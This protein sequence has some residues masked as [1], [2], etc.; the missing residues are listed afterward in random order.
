M[1]ESG[2]ETHSAFLKIECR[3]LVLFRIVELLCE[4]GITSTRV[5]NSH[6]PR[7]D[8]LVQRE[9]LLRRGF[10]DII[11]TVQNLVRPFTCASDIFHEH[12]L[13]TTGK[14]LRNVPG[15]A[16]PQPLDFLPEDSD[17]LKELSVWTFQIGTS[18]PPCNSIQK[19]L[20]YCQ[21]GTAPRKIF[22][23]QANPKISNPKI[24]RG[25]GRS[26]DLAELKE[27]FEAVSVVR[28]VSPT[29]VINDRGGGRSAEDLAL[30]F[31]ARPTKKGL[32]RMWPLN[33]F[34]GVETLHKCVANF[35]DLFG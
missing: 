33:G 11:C 15:P 5:Y 24:S 17:L 2:T 14:P 20:R 34:C 18:G 7:R 29:F 6:G 13:N 8:S 28:T 9:A 22:R 4:S 31:R 19:M 1:H 23:A 35:D 27:S 21:A 3:A 25:R 12:G 16:N 26:M 10:H 32:R 30:K